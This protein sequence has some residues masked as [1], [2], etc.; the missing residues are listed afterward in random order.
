MPRNLFFFFPSS[1]KRSCFQDRISF[2]FFSFL[3]S[4]PWFSPVFLCCQGLHGLVLTRVGT[5]CQAA[6]GG[7]SLTSPQLGLA[8]K[9]GCGGLGEGFLNRQTSPN[10]GVF[11]FNPPDRG[12]VS[13]TSENISRNSREEK[14]LIN[15]GYIYGY[16][17]GWSSNIV[18]GL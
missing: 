17:C 6:P 9:W 18:G 7:R 14:C 16:L 5:R 15:A 10:E 3:R 11:T 4:Y 8:W 1:S 12:E 2:S 13:K